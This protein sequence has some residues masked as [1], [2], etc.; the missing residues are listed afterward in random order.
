MGYEVL[1]DSMAPPTR[2]VVPADS[3]NIDHRR[4]VFPSTFTAE[5]RREEWVDM[6]RVHGASI[7]DMP[8]I[9]AQ[10]FTGILKNYRDRKVSA[11]QAAGVPKE[12]IEVICQQ[13]NWEHEL[14]MLPSFEI[15]IF[16]QVWRAADKT[17]ALQD[18]MWFLTKGTHRDQLAAFLTRDAVT[19]LVTDSEDG[20][21][22]ALLNLF[23]T[24]ALHLAEV[25]DGKFLAGPI[26]SLWM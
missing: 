26:H 25:D 2:G 6:A 4:L 8:R 10:S 11:A 21:R 17:T 1:Y 5:Q 14:T 22:K 19:E 18:F 13:R 24:Q 15:L 7:A 20:Y 3:M 16:V 12:L 23:I 9:M